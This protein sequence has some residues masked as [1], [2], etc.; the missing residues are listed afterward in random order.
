MTTPNTTLQDH[1]KVSAEGNNMKSGSRGHKRKGDEPVAKPPKKKCAENTFVLEGSSESVTVKEIGE[2]TAKS[3]EIQERARKPTLSGRVP[4]MPAH[5]A[6]AGYEG[7]KRGS[8][9]ERR[10]LQGN[11]GRR[12]ILQSPLQREPPRKRLRRQ[13][14][15]MKVG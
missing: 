5:L 8:E 12:V 13:N 14:P 11:R 15:A 10:N 1:P 9:A 7:E 6:E 3:G 2:G 4:L